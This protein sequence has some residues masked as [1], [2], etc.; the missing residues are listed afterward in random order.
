MFNEHLIM[1]I[2]TYAAALTGL[3]QVG[4]SSFKY[5]C[6]CK[7]VHNLVLNAYVSLGAARVGACVKS[8]KEILLSKKICGFAAH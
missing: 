6:F 8:T 2:T 4:L 1:S 5:C 3:Q 7:V